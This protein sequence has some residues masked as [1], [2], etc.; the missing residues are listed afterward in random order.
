MHQLYQLSCGGATNFF[1]TG[2]LSPLIV[3]KTIP[4]FSTQKAYMQ[5]FSGAAKATNWEFEP[6]VCL[7]HAFF[8]ILIV[9]FSESN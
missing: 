4:S 5:S 9:F 3:S 8:N 7:K 1:L 6:G 2:L